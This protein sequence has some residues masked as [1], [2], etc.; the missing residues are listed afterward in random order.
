MKQVEDG[1]DCHLFFMKEIDFVMKLMTTYGTLEPTD[2]RTR[3]KFKRDGV[4][5]TK[6]Y[7]YSEVIANKFLY[8]NQVDDNNNR[9]HVI[10]LIEKTWA[11]KYWPDRCFSCYLYVS[12]ANVNHT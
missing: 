7:I 3:R 11:T 8:R 1:V 2:N 6:E 10:I 5:E 4:M 9:R 12:E